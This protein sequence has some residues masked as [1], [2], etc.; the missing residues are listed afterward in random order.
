MSEGSKESKPNQYVHT[1]TSLEVALYYAE[2][3]GKTSK[4]QIVEIDLHEF[5]G[6]IVDISNEKGC[7]RHGVRRGTKAHHFAVQHEVVMLQGYIQP[8]RIGK[9]ALD[10]SKLNVPNSKWTSCDNFK[11]SLP[12]S[13]RRELRAWRRGSPSICRDLGRGPPAMCDDDAVQDAVLKRVAEEIS[14]EIKKLQD[15]KRLID[16]MAGQVEERIRK[17]AERKEQ[18]RQKKLEEERR[19]E[20]VKR[21][22]GEEERQEEERREERRRQQVE[23]E[24]EESRGPRIW[25]RCCG[26]DH[27]LKVFD[28]KVLQVALGN[29]GYIVLWDWVKGHKWSGV[30][31]ELSN[32]L[33]GRGYHQARAN[34]VAL[35]PDS[36]DHYFVQF[37]DGTSQWRGPD[38]FSEVVQ[39]YG[40]L[41][42]VAFGPQ[43]SWYA[44]W[45]DGSSQ[46]S[47]LPRSLC[48][49]LDSNRH[50]S[51]CCL[52]ISGIGAYQDVDDAAWFMSWDDGRHPTWKL[53]GGVPP[54]L[55]DKV[56]EVQSDG[57]S[58]RSVEFG[59]HGDWV[60]RCSD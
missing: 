35:G 13:V 33:N 9:K 42:L 12:E 59:G 21:K 17:Q 30:P 40:G 44:K 53:S 22:R 14:K 34:L 29:Q 23:R 28:R 8:S 7:D 24:A 56:R 45:S 10:T 3:F 46:W 26:Q 20:E 49:M 60:L 58:V 32:K 31:R 18:E 4:H 15:E 50:R 48:N 51:I 55:S 37:A 19:L 57:G 52:S 39:A 43:N 6:Q 54:A 5:F 36:E 1:T 47:N 27:L 16:S 38:N 25:A 41:R 2:A 11:A